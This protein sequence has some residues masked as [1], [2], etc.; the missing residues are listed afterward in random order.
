MILGE[1]GREKAHGEL[2]L[3]SVH[4]KL[5]LGRRVALRDLLG[6]V[7]AGVVTHPVVRLSVDLDVALPALGALTIAN[8][9]IVRQAGRQLLTSRTGAIGWGERRSHHH[10]YVHSAT[11]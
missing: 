4:N 5:G 7:A 11:H 10:Q 1:D 2:N 9:S 3:A 6:I 8:I